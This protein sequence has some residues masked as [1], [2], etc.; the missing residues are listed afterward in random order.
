MFKVGSI[1]IP[2]TN[3]EKSTEWY[4]KNLGVKI[5]DH[6]EDGAG[7]YFPGSTT[8]LGLV[9]VE[10]PQPSEFVIK[11]RKKNVYYNFIVQNIEEAHQYLNNHGV[12][13]TAI[14]DFDGMKGFDFFDLDG[15][16]F[17][18]VDE[19]INSPFH[20]NNI[21]ELQENKYQ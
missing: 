6:W 18:V 11:G 17:S 7:F 13:T 4:Q 19:D 1:F 3:I 14:E 10:T 2:V 9:Q 12:V 8:Q 5:I 16:A 20:S 21:M 15:N